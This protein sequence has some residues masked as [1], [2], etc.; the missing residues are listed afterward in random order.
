MAKGVKRIK[1]T[2]DGKV[3]SS[4]SVPNKKV[5]IHPDQYV[6]FEVDLWHQGTPEADKKKTLTWILQDRRKKTVIVQRAQPAYEPKKISIP[7]ALCGP[8][9]YYLEASISGQRDLVNQTGLI[10]RGDCPT[11]ILSSKWS[12]TR[13]GKDVRKDHLFNYGETVYL[14]LMTE[15]LN[16][17][18]NLCI[19]I[20]RHLD[21]QTDP[22]VYRYTSVDVT[23]GEINLEIKSTNTWYPKLKNIKEKEE[24]YIKV[25]DPSNR[26]YIPDEKYNDTVHARFLRINKKIVSEEIKPPVNLSPLKTGKPEKTKERFELCRFQS[27]SITEDKKK[28]TLIFDNGENLKNVSNPKTPIAKTIL[29][30]FDKYDIT[31]D[32]K[33]ILNNVLQYLLGAQYS[34]IKI[35]GHACVIGKEQY[36]QKLSQQRSNAVKKIFIDGGLDGNRIVSTGRGEVNPTDDK[37][38]RDNIKHKDE[39]EYIENRRVDITFNAFGHDAQTIIYETIATSHEQNLT[40]DITEYQNK[41][42]FKDVKHKKNI[43]INSPEYPNSI[44]KVTNKLDFPV[45]SNLSVS[46]P[47]PILYIWPKVFANEYNIHVH[48]CRYFSNDANTTVLVKA[49]ADIKWDFH[50]FLNLSN[51]LSVK[52]Q[53]LSPEK[54]KEMQSKA[55]KI[56]AEKRWKQTE[57]DFGVAIDAKWDKIEGDKYNGH[58]DA[59]KK[60][61]KK[62]KQFYSVFASLK[63]FS[64]SIT[65]QTKGTVSKT[66]L[67]KKW[68]LWVE[69]DPPNFCLGAEW[70]LARGQNKGKETLEIGTAIEFYFK[71]EPLIALGLNIDLLAGLV[72]LGV[73]ATTAGSGNVAAMKI[74]NEVRDWLDED[75]NTIKLKMYIDLEITGTING[76]SKLNLNTASDK[77]NGEAKLETILKIELRAGIEIKASAV[78]IIGEAYASAEVSGKAVGSVTFGHG[79]LFEKNS[80]QTSIYYQPKLNFD[81]LRVKGVIKAKIGL[82]IKKGV[83]KGDHD[84][85]LVDYKYEE[86]LFDPFDVIQQFEKITGLSSKIQLL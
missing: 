21:Y 28:P 74:F 85:E 82:L 20:F 67:G 62:I 64:K 4:L 52:W 51:K 41:A 49:Y 16:G 65:E 5:V 42:C 14:N 53:N 37:Q 24:F 11:R 22:L 55:G 30:D 38:G 70:S 35:D 34:T 31:S 71:A 2:G 78:F 61:E 26:L 7:K 77:N 76:F 84:K 27:I 79:L 86:N 68:P 39:K 46:N 3:I 29:F 54:H 13:D 32:A 17:H 1:W 73:A 9:E 58:Y 60:Y 15:G 80:T 6:S 69:M 44:D 50:F 40:I 56:G 45:K 8:F 12:T 81:G 83:F 75:D 48:S 72:Q 18:Q 23:D 33:T 36:N 19:D 59:T 66:R 25:F 43:K 57:I 47:L 63:E 10:I